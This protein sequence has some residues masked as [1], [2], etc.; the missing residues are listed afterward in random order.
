M[1]TKKNSPYANLG[2]AAGTKP[3]RTPVRRHLA[4]KRDENL[5]DETG[6]YNPRRT[7]SASDIASAVGSR[8]GAKPA[9]RVFTA[10][11]ELNASSNKD[12][13]QSIAYLLDS[14][15]SHKDVF[16]RTAGSDMDPQERRD[17]IASAMRDDA[18]F[19]VLGQELLL[20]IKDILDYEGFARKIYRQRPLAQGE[21]FRIAKDVRVPAWVVGQDGQS[22]ESRVGGKY[23]QPDEFKITA[24]ATVDIEDIYM[25]NYDVL[26][27]AQETARQSIA[28]E[29]DRRG[30][31][32]ADR[33]GQAVNSVTNFTT[34]GLAELENIRYQVER[35]RLA[36]DK[37]VIHRQE[38]GDIIK[39]MSQQV[40]PMTE[41]EL[42]LAGYIG[43]IYNARV[44]T[45]AGMGDAEVVKPGRV[46]GFTAPE[47]LGEMG[48]RIELFS[49]PFN[50]LSH[51][52]TVKGWS[53]VEKIGFGISNPRGVSLGRRVGS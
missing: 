41:R 36:L 3:S 39:V 16:A 20:P 26:D 21:L 38:M 27:R 45:S 13:L 12:A 35:H 47:N 10:G 51:G 43:R 28:E 6:A 29:E 42:I 1:A 44:F 33:A 18:G 23:V 24:F 5:F 49:E 48:I 53:F 2:R 22:L 34:L 25:M 37:F 32:L 50:K 11:G 7:A 14:M 30:L 46:Y 15:S 19:K 52:Q 31:A 4:S 9:D 40:D 17:I 8:K